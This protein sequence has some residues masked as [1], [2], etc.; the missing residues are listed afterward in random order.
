M[1]LDDLREFSMDE[2][3]SALGLTAKPSASERLL[4]GLG[5]FG[6]GLLVG[7][8]TA[9]LLAPRSGK[10]LRADL[11]ER[12]GHRRDEEAGSPPQPDTETPDAE[13]HT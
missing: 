1:K 7:A 6:V 12:L 11:A 13:A 2:I 5:I 3:L 4:S 10:A 9:L 8:G